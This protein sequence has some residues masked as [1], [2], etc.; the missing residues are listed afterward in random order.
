VPFVD[1]LNTLHDTTNPLLPGAFAVW[2]DPAEP[3]MFDYIASYSP[4]E[5]ITAQPYPAVLGIGGL[6]DNRVGYWESAKWVAKI[7]ETSTSGRP[8][9][10][11][12]NMT[13]GHQGHA[14]LMPELEHAAFVNAFTLW[15]M[16]R[17]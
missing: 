1:V 15:A 10:L 16:G 17:T 4:Y 9:L 8:A 2:G 5:N 6:L 3:A 11:R 14:G 12:I 7:R 13:A